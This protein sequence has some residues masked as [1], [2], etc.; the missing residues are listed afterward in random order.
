MDNMRF[1]AYHGV[2]QQ[3]AAVGNYFTVGLSI[4]APMGE[5]IDNDNLEGT[6]DYARVYELV[7]K[8]MDI[9]SKLIEHA[10]GRILKTL[11]KSF[12]QI[13]EIEISLS[14]QNPPMGADLQSAGVV[15]KE[16]YN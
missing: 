9:P 3:E 14:K 12:P 5:A 4:E 6:I 11:K 8:E 7:K 16:T 10:A 1:Y 13:K 2:S 15:L